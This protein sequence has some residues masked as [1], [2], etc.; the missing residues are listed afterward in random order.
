MPL[1]SGWKVQLSD[2][3]MVVAQLQQKLPSSY[4]TLTA[5]ISWRTVEDSA[6]TWPSKLKALEKFL[7]AKLPLESRRLVVKPARICWNAY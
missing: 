6:E 5:M 1:N 7:T 2:D 4:T 3:H